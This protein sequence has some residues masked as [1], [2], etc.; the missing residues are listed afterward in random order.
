MI[1]IAD[2]GSTKT[3]WRLI[4]AERNIHQFRTLGFNP[5]FQGTEDISKEIRQ[6]LVPFIKSVS[7]LAGS[8]NNLNIHFYGAGCST[9]NKCSIVHQA[10]QENFKG[11]E[12][13]IHHDLLAASR[14]LCGKNE[15]IVAILGTGS[16]SCYYD[17]NDVVENV[18]SIGF[19]LGDEGSGAD[20]GKTFIKAYL[21][22]EVP[23]EIAKRFDH[24]FK[25]GKEEILEG[26]YKNSMPS[27][28]LASFSRFVYQNI[29]EPF[30]I[31]LV[32]G[33]FREFFDKHICKY[34]KHTEIPMNC[35]GSVGFYYNSILKAVAEE[36]RVR[37]GKILETP[38]A[39]L[40]LYHLD[41]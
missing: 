26:V 31:Q 33:C 30:M 8:I 24:R 1:L 29:K 12:V 6:N 10:I 34:S 37:I 2:S 15:G 32:S 16:N 13:N 23:E 4:D 18:Y 20:I 38:I 21:Y 35:V 9:E 3:D 19:I 5:Y 22:N 25:I 11:A 36:K 40:A 39:G 17:G 27:R 7:S 41:E 14:A 28:Y